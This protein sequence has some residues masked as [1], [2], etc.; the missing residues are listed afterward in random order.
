MVVVSLALSTH[1]AFGQPIVTTGDLPLT[2][3]E[4]SEF[5]KTAS[6]DDVWEWIRRLQS[7]GAQIH[8]T[9]LG[10]TTEGRAMP[11]VIASRPLITTAEQAWASGKPILYPERHTR[12]K[13]SSKS[14]SPSWLRSRMFRRPFVSGRNK[15]PSPNRPA[16]RANRVQTQSGKKLRQLK[17]I[18][19]LQN[20][21]R[22]P[23]W[24]R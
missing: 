13:P 1:L 22:R 7:L 24:C 14:S 8:V 2:V 11:L 18:S 21:N 4:S 6:F 9:T 5:T 16:R 20:R 19:V 23:A 12:A 3:A 17:R 10:T 15:R